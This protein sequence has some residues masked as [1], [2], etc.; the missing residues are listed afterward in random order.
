MK[1]ERLLMIS[2]LLCLYPLNVVHCE[3]QP[4]QWWFK[5]H[6]MIQ[7]NLREIDATMDIDRYIQDL[8]DWK[9]NV[10]KL[11]VGGIVA[12]Y[13]TEVKYHWRN[14]FMKGDLTDTVLKRLHAEGIRVAGR[15]DVSKINEKFAAEHPEWLYVSE[16]GK[17]V[18]YNGQVHTCVSG[19]YQ[20]EYM[21]KF[22]GEAID[23]YPLDGVFFNMSGYQRRDYS[24]NYHGICQCNNCRRL[25]KQYSGMDLP[26][27]QD[28]NPTYRKYVEF[29]RMMTTKQTNRVR[30]FFKAKRSDLML[31]V[32]DVI[33]GESGAP[34]GRGAY[35][36]TDKVKSTMLTMGRKQ[37]NNTANHF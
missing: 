20:Q 9:V 26:P 22:L 34:L 29:T 31:Y 14:T 25:F 5:P 33:R 16:A 27:T 6:R 13:P 37:Y 35:Y 15:F 19:G 8:K 10:V 12:N 23:R 1:T 24:R 32:V 17:N 18:N 11:N 21:Y 30:T 28:N 7:T 2:F 36:D 3:D 4:S